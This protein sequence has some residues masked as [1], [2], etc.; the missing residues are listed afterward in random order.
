MSPSLRKTVTLPIVL[1]LLAAA[2][3]AV[4]G[5]A[6]ADSSGKAD[7]RCNHADKKPGEL[8]KKKA[9]NAVICLINKQR[10]SHGRGGLDRNY[11]LIEAARKHSGTMARKGCFSHECRGEKGLEGRLR[12]VH[13]LHGGL[14]RWAYA[15]NIAYGT[16]GHGTPR[17]IVRRWMNSSG[18]R[19][20]ILS[21][22]YEDIG[23]GFY[24]KSGRGYYTA[25]FGLAKG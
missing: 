16:G 21:G 18:H 4:P 7:K 3:F 11:K 22:T 24:N 20:N 9:R 2:L 6:S 17:D 5:T 25:D 13:Y 23:V 1:A 15:E 14:S 10:R 19:A 12:A 8:G